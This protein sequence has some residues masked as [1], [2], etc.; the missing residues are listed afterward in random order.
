[1]LE[2]LRALPAEAPLQR[3]CVQLQRTLDELEL[4]SRARALQ[5][6]RHRLGISSYSASGAPVLRRGPTLSF[7]ALTTLGQPRV[8]DSPLETRA[9]ARDQ[10]AV[11]ALETALAELPRQAARVGL[12]AARWSRARFAR[13]LADVLASAPGRPRG[14][15]GAA[16]ELTDLGGL[17]GRRFTHLFVC[18]V[19]D[20]EMPTRAMDDSL[21]SDADRVQLNRAL[22][23]VALPLAAHQEALQALW[24]RAA[25]ASADDVHQSWTRGDEDGAPQL[26][27]SL[28][29][30][31]APA[32]DQIVA[33]PRDTIPL[34]RDARTLSELIAR[35]ALEARGDR[36]A[37]LSTPDPDGGGALYAALA[38]HDRPRA[39]RLEHAIS[40]EWQRYR[41]FRGDIDAHPFV[42]A[43][44]DPSLIAALAQ[45]LP[46]TAAA[47]LS[48]TS[49]ES[50]AA[51]PFRFFLRFVLRAQ[52]PEETG[53]EIDHF[54]FGRLRHQVLERVFRRFDAV[55]R[56]PLRAD[57][58]E[59]DLVDEVC[60]DALAEWRQTE[61]VGHP[62]LFA[63]KERQLREQV[64]AL[65]R[66]EAAA[67]VAE[68]CRPA[69]FEQPFGPLAIAA[70]DGDAV[71]LSGKIDRIDVGDGRAVV[72]D[73]KPGSK[74]IYQA[75]LSADASC[76]T[77][78]QLPIYAAAVRAELGIESVAACFYSLKD[79]ATTRAVSAPAHFA[80]ALVQLVRP[81]R[82]G[83]FT[84][85]P[86][87]D[88][89]ERCDMVAACRVRHVNAMEDEP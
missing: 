43:L 55:G 2:R 22:G 46:G 88:A 42:G 32:D 17:G 16:V 3:H 87:A 89:C 5:R 65:V 66:S 39:A 11:A 63:V 49:I 58:F 73:Y 29:D 74:R 53:E 52:T 1:V 38:Q 7:A 33:L 28:I 8:I 40:M 36:S 61:P 72:F 19:L 48:A 68:G 79:A 14:V 80:T 4:F 15:R 67:P 78:W 44:H 25:L 86:R 54:A 77:A 60:D 56:W 13:L 18:G 84:V 70:P 6:P 76:V 57:Q 35:A 20:G 64:A 82:S 83:D 50:Y 34:A 26:R 71:Y 41:F 30:E 59:L 23:K 62:A 75:L 51:C 45:K 31:L 12:R 10:A 37:R 24:F 21:L 47:P 69:R 9:I 85:R 81:L 27:S